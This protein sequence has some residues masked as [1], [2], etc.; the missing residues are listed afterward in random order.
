MQSNKIEDFP[1]TVV[2]SPGV[3]SHDQNMAAMRGKGGEG[4]NGPKWVCEEHW[5]FTAAFYILDLV[6]LGIYMATSLNN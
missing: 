1:W 6:E 5:R 4:Y 3:K 2:E